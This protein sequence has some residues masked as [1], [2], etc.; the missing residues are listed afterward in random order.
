[1]EIIV[2]QSAL[3]EL[4]LNPG[5]LDGLA[6]DGGPTYAAVDQLLERNKPRLAKTALRNRA[7]RLVAA[8][9]LI[10]WSKGIEVGAIDGFVG[11]QVRQARIEYTALMI[12]GAKPQPWRDQL[13]EERPSDST[14]PAPVKTTWPTQANVEKFFGKPGENLTRLTPPYPMRLDW[15]HKTPLKDYLIHE[16]VHDSAMRVFKRVLG[17]YGEEQIKKLGLDRWAGCY[18]NRSMRGGSKLSMHAW[19]IAHDFWAAMNQLQWGRDKAVFAKPEYDVWWRCWTEE[20]HLSLGKARNFDWMHVQAA[21][22]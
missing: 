22:L 2:L 10:Y 19:A 14:M 16:K 11:P 15:D 4:G 8:E 7:T 17:H 1:M 9:Q 12:A 13:M 3:K 18:S 6:K 5:A 21:R 20:G